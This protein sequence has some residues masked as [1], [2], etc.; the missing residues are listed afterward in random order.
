MK[1]FGIRN[2]IFVALLGCVL[3]RSLGQSCGSTTMG[4]LAPREK[5]F[6]DEGWIALTLD[7]VQ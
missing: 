4:H 6:E 2:A 1:D 3:V 7:S 5:S